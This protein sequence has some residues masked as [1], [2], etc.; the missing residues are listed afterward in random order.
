MAES[1]RTVALKKWLKDRQNVLLI[2]LIAFTIIIRLYYFFKVG[3]QPIWWDEGDYLA[4]AKVWAEGMSTPE[5]W[6]HFT[7]MRPL[8]L[9]LLFAGLFKIGFN[10]LIIR[11]FTLLVPSILSV[12][13]I[14][15]LGRDLYNSKHGL[16]AGVMMSV[17]WV[18]LF[19]SFR[20]LT[21]ILSVCFGLL[22]LYFFWSLY[23][24][25]SRPMGLYLCVLFGVLGFSTRFPTALVP[26]VCA[27]YLLVTRKF[28]VL[29]DKTL[30]KSL[31]LFALIMLPYLIF[32][33]STKFYFLRFY[34]GENAVTVKQPIAWYVIGMLPDLFHSVWFIVFLIGL[35]TFL[36]LFMGLDLIWKHKETALNSD[37]F[38][39]LWTMVHLIFYVVILRGATDRWLLMVMPALFIIS[40][41]GFVVIQQFFKAYSK[42]LGT[43]VVLLLLGWGFVQQALHAN[44]LIV[45]KKETY[46]EVKLAGLWIK[47]HSLPTDAVITAS[48]VQNQYYSERQSY[49]FRTDEHIWKSCTDPYGAVNSNNTCQQFTEESFDRKFTRIKPTY[50]IVSVFEPVF[51]PQ[52]AYTYGPRHNLTAVQTYLGTDNR[53]LLIIYKV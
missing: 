15:L 38:V 11:F 12:Y 13:L 36:P 40:A 43:I 35:S 29:K 34:F 14:F 47:E 6:G 32:F 41:R 20:L 45:S 52:W 33:V 7:T 46:K 27:L 26:I 25:K 23:I 2:L 21:D 48:V 53:P 50:V 28:A 10:E 1:S 30:W 17:Y 5:W 44:T 49:D 42:Q 51:T 18:F 16:I 37:I 39:F 3:E 19:Y 9:P 8:L 24:K 22:S 31:A 4:I